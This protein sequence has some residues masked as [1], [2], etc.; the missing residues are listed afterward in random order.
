MTEEIRNSLDELVRG[1]LNKSK[2]PISYAVVAILF[3]IVLSSNKDKYY[4]E[5]H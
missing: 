5:L 4:S 3:L 2:T 1:V